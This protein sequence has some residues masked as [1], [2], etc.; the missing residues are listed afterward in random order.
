M[1]SNLTKV[2]VL[3]VPALLAFTACNTTDRTARTT[4]ATDEGTRARTEVPKNAFVRFVDVYQGP[5]NLFFGDQKVFSGDY[6]SVSDY[7]SVPAE[8]H[9]FALRDNAHATGDPLAKN[10]EG[11]G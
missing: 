11:L 3:V 10:S 8:R 4:P 6:K 1:H 9:E 2:S 7:K 5:A